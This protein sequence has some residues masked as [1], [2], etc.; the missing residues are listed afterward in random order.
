[1]SYS[2]F[3]SDTGSRRWI[4]ILLGI[5]INICLGTVY[6]W[7]V[8]RKPIEETLQ[9]NATQSGMPYMFFLFMYAVTMLFAGK[10]IDKYR[11][12]WIAIIGGL[13]VASGWFMAGFANNIFILT[14][15]YGV[16]AGAGVGIIY[17][18]PISVVAKWF[19][20]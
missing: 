11:P 20:E 9:I 4:Y 5:L 2:N 6:S 3:K 13:L 14:A 15:A 16:I 1:M 8:F 19:P 17:G 10:F 12:R 7:S 18:V